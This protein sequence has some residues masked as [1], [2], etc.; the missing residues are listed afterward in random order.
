[1]V[2]LIVK[3]KYSKFWP[4][5][6]VVSL[7]SAVI[8]FYFYWNSS[9]I[10]IKG[11][12]RL[13]AFILFSV[14]VLSIYKLNESQ[15]EITAILDNELIEFQY[16]SKNKIIH[17][18]EWVAS[19]ISSIKIDEM[20]NRSLYNDIILSDRCL[21]FRRNNQSDWNYLNSINGRVVPLSQNNAEELLRFL[22]KL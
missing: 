1:M 13:I 11:Y 7:I 12:L 18:E 15:I 20:P 5:I 22:K 21:R 17:S 19:D 4:I 14:G 2:K 9:D 6:T 8:S 3:E 16:R 10:L